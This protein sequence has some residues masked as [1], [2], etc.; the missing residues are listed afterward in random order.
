MHDENFNTGS[1]E[2]NNN[3]I[4]PNQPQFT[5]FNPNV[6]PIY[7]PVYVRP[8]VPG[9]GLGIASMV[10]GICGIICS[11]MLL[12]IALLAIL[13][14]FTNHSS[15]NTYEDLKIIM[16]NLFTSGDSENAVGLVL[17]SLIIS[18]LAIIFA[19]VSLQR[20]YRNGISKSGFI[21]SMI[22]LVFILIFSLTGKDVLLD[23]FTKSFNNASQTDVHLVGEWEAAME[24]YG[25]GSGGYTF[26]DDNTGTRT[27]EDD[28]T[29]NFK[30]HTK[31]ATNKREIEKQLN[32]LG[33]DFKDVDFLVSIGYL[34]IYIDNQEN[35][36]VWRYMIFKENGKDTLI[37][38]SERSS[39]LEIF[40]SKS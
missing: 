27:F 25:L 13:L 16:G 37:T 12:L 21:L 26:N 36:G 24:N 40:S 17:G 29:T 9:K 10:L 2:R 5:Q 22:S 8:K 35:A 34:Y 23:G 14:K 7:Y 18:I 39:D 11:S 3:P 20:G 38:V 1:P 31:A 6:Q 15:G 28:P 32:A 4:P 30:W 33:S 19:T